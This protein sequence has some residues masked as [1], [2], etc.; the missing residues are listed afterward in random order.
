MTWTSEIPMLCWHVCFHFKHMNRGRKKSE[1]FNYETKIILH[2]YFFVREIYTDF[3][4]F[5]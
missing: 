1:K 2:C 5:A 3:Y 4:I